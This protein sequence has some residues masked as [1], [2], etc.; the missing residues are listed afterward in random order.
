MTT[1]Q[2]AAILG[3]RI[4]SVSRLVK[5]GTLKGERFGQVWLVYEDSVLEYQRNTEGKQKN[6][7]T[8]GKI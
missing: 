1:A 4:E 6:D 3:L 7:R 8:R 5:K 2:A